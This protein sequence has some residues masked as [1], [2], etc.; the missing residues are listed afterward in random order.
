M[1]HQVVDFAS[2]LI[3]CWALIYIQPLYIHTYKAVIFTNNESGFCYINQCSSVNT[4]QTH[5]G[6]KNH[7]GACKALKIL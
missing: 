6:H 7:L 4:L 5:R 1:Y 2:D 3:I